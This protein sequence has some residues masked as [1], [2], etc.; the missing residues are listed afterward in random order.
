MVIHVNILNLGPF[1]SL[2]ATLCFQT[3]ERMKRNSQI[4]MDIMGQNCY[5]LRAPVHPRVEAVLCVTGEAL[6]EAQGSV[7]KETI[8]LHLFF[9]TDA[10]HQLLQR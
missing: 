7:W 9:D 1:F 10:L 8:P 5:K 2:K 4:Y 3:T 6:L